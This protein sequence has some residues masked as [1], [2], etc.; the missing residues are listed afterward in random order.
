MLKKRTGVVEFKGRHRVRFESVVE[1]NSNGYPEAVVFAEIYKDMKQDEVIRMQ[2]RHADMWCV[3]EG[4]KEIMETS[5]LLQKPESEKDTHKALGR[6][7][8]I[9]QSGSNQTSLY[10][11]VAKHHDRTLFYINFTQKSREAKKT[12]NIS[13]G[14][15]E[16]KAAAAQLD[17]FVRCAERSYFEIYRGKGEKDAQT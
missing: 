8:K 16:F 6:F 3:V 15:T 12:L 5:L 2:L 9:T 10:F 1:E 17:H 11:G 14:E 7:R 4:A 13:L